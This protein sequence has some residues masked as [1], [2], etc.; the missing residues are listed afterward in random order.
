MSRPCEACDNTA[1]WILRGEFVIDDEDQYEHITDL[2]LCDWHYKNMID[3]IDTETL[4]DMAKHDI[5]VI[6]IFGE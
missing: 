2:C 5:K 3:T 6:G 4:M 1:V